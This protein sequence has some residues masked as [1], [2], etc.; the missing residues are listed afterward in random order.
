MKLEING[1]YE[2]EVLKESSNK[3]KDYSIIRDVFGKTHYYPK[4]LLVSKISL[5]VIEKKNGKFFFSTELKKNKLGTNLYSNNYELNKIYPFKYEGTNRYCSIADKKEYEVVNLIDINHPDKKLTAKALYWQLSDKFSFDIILCEVVKKFPEIDKIQVKQSYL[6]LKHPFF[7]INKEYKFYSL[8]NHLNEIEN[9]YIKLLGEDGI[10]H[11]LHTPFY[12]ND[13]LSYSYRFFGINK[14]GNL[15]FRQFVNFESIVKYR[16][17]KRL[18][19]DKF[20]TIEDNPILTKMFEDYDCYQNLWIISFCNFLEEE[21]S[22]SIF[23]GDFEESLI[24]IEVLIE[25]ENWILNSG[26][27]NSFKDL[28]RE[29]IY[30]VT[31]SKLIEFKFKKEALEIVINNQQDNFFRNIIETDRYYENIEILNYI[32]S[33]TSIFDKEKYYLSIERVINYVL[34]IGKK[35][36]FTINNTTKNKEKFQLSLLITKHLSSYEKKIFEYQFIN[37][38]KRDKYYEQNKDLENLSRLITLLILIYKDSNKDD[39]FKLCLAKLFKFKALQ[40]NEI[41]VKVSFLKNSL[42]LLFDKIINIDKDSYLW[43]KFEN[44]ISYEFLEN[45]I[46]ETPVINKLLTLKDYCFNKNEIK[47]QLLGNNRYGYTIELFENIG[48]LP[49]KFFNDNRLNKILKS[50]DRILDCEIN[51]ID[52]F[53]G[54]IYI[55]PILKVDEILSNNIFEVN[56][57]VKGVVKTIEEYGVFFDLGEYDG[58][59]HNSKLPFHSCILNVGEELDLIIIEIVDDNDK[60][61]ISLSLI[62]ESLKKNVE[63]DSEYDCYILSKKSKTIQVVTKEG[64]IGILK[65]SNLSY[66]ESYITYLNNYDKIRAQVEKID[67]NKIEFN[68]KITFKNPF[69]DSDFYLNKFFRTKIVEITPSLISVKFLDFNLIGYSRVFSSFLELENLKL[70]DIVDFEVKEINKENKYILGSINYD[71]IFKY[72]L[73]YETTNTDNLYYSEIAST[74]EHLAYTIDIVTLKTNYLYLSKI[75]YGFIQSP[76]SYYLEIFI[77]F[78][79]II[80]KMKIIKLD[81]LFENILLVKSIASQI[82]DYINEQDLTVKIFPNINL[83]QQTLK[84]LLFFNSNDLESYNFLVLGINN[85]DSDIISKM[86]SLVLSTNS[87][88]NELRTDSFIFD[89]W[90]ILYN[91]LKEG[92]L[93]IENE[94]EIEIEKRKEIKSI[95]VQG[96]NINNEFKASI[97]KPVHDGTKRVLIENLKLKIKLAEE[98]EDLELSSHLKLKLDEFYNDYSVKGVKHSFMKSIAAFANTEGGNIIIGLEDDSNILGIECEIESEDFNFKEKDKYLNNLDILINQYIGNN[99]QSNIEFTDFIKIENKNLLWIKIKKSNFP[100]FLKLDKEGKQKK[101]FYIRA[102]VSSPK[103]EIDEIFDYCKIRFRN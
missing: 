42:K 30:E 11:K 65:I 98:S 61:L 5:Y 32:L 89:R 60:K 73:K 101:E 72:D 8:D 99:F 79:E 81:L 86:S 39:N 26:F 69:I 15:I 50:N 12:T 102:R 49:Y 27:I 25:F 10:V 87:T 96:E 51:L 92:L 54:N 22:K 48:I 20:R 6:N 3:E 95:I 63:V 47:G 82:I 91:Y 67:D 59:L 33:Y 52:E 88:P 84:I 74:Y 40:S 41:S 21:F 24:F 1:F 71:R 77:R 38:Y 80:D 55:N 31:K 37:S 66:Q 4:Y 62:H 70:N 34:Y 14:A 78:E 35:D 7:E 2:F 44:I 57:I 68:S 75:F 17:L 16:A 9:N 93:I 18:T 13:D 45:I 100:V 76:K 36:F 64:F 53:T 97:F 103:L 29:S 58:L 83:I 56:S 28:G 90:N 43:E 46:F 19:Y 85:K 94:D 23:K